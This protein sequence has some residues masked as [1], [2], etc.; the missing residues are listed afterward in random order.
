[1]MH[2]GL[3]F[4]HF[5]IPVAH[6][7]STSSLVSLL[8]SFLLLGAR[9]FDR[10]SL[11]H[12]FCRFVCERGTSGLCLFYMCEKKHLEDCGGKMQRSRFVELL[13]FVLYLFVPVAHRVS[14]SILVS[15]LASCWVP[16]NS[17][18]C[19]GVTGAPVLSVCLRRGE[20]RQLSVSHV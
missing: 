9:A 5:F 19:S 20:F 11:G 4:P 8:A 3:I 16:W 7:I 13:L 18:I 14:T 1:M 15:T 6:R 12:P 10:A 2:A 17:R